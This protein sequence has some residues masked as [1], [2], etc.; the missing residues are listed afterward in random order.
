[1][2]E[3]CQESGPV[4]NYTVWGRK[5]MPVYSLRFAGLLCRPP[6]IKPRPGALYWG[7]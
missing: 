4:C 2:R 7:R 1:M 6:Y 5:H 3:S